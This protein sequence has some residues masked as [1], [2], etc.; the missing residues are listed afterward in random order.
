MGRLGRAVIFA[1]SGF[2][3]CA[4]ISYVLVLHF[5][6]RNDRELEAAMTSFFCFGPVRAGVAFALG[7][8]R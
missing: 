2:L 4:V 3:I 7:L 8:L 6:P 1:I 5:S